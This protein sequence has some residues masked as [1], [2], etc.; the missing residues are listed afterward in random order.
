[1]TDPLFIPSPFFLLRAPFWS[2]EKWAQ[3]LNESNWVEAI[4]QLYDSDEAFQEAVAVASPNLD[5]EINKGEKK[6][7]EKIAYSLLKYAIRMSSRTTPFGLFSFISLGKWGEVTE[8]EINSLFVQ[9]G[10][11]PDLSWVYAYIEKLYKNKELFPALFVYKNPLIAEAQDRF[12]LEFH[13]QIEKDDHNQTQIKSIDKTIV[14]EA[15]FKLTDQEIEVS[16]L[17]D[18][19]EKKIDSSDRERLLEVILQLYEQQFLLP[20]LLPSLLSVS[21]FQDVLQKLPRDRF[22]KH[23]GNIIEQYQSTTIGEGILS[24]RNCMESM[25]EGVEVG[26]KLQVDSFYNKNRPILPKTIANAAI[27]TVNLYATLSRKNHHKEILKS[28]HEKFLEKYG[29]HRIVPILEVLSPEQ[30]L[31]DFKSE[32]LP[33]ISSQLEKN[34]EKWL[35]NQ[36]HDVEEEIVLTDEVVEDLLKKSGEKPFDPYEIIPSTDVFCQVLAES[37]EEIDRGN[38]RLLECYPGWQGGGTFGRFNYLFSQ[39][40]REEIEAFFREEEA[41]EPNALFVQTSIWP[42]TGNEANVSSL[43]CIRRHC[44]DLSSTEKKEADLTLE[45]VYVGANLEG[46]Y[47]TLR[48]GDPQL[49]C[50]PGHLLRP[51]LMSKPIELMRT[52]TLNNQNVIE[53]DFWGGLRKE[54][55]F[56][57]RIRYKKSILYPAMWQFD[58]TLFSHLPK[59]KIEQTFAIWSDTRKLPKKCLLISGDQQL[60]IETQHPAIRKEI[61]NRIMKKEVVQ[62]KEYLPSSWLKTDKGHHISELVIPLL[63][64]PKYRKEKDF[65]APSFQEVSSKQR[66]K[67]PGSEWISCKLYMSQREVDRFLINHL[68]DLGRQL[69]KEEKIYGWFFVRYH[70]PDFHLRF[71]LHLTQKQFFSEVIEILQHAVYEWIDNHFI[72]EFSLNTYE[73]ELERYGGSEMIELAEALFCVDAIG[74]CTQLKTVLLE[75]KEMPRSVYYALSVILFL[76]G[77]GLSNQE[78]INFIHIG[79]KEKERLAGFRSHKERLIADANSILVGKSENFHMQSLIEAAELRKPFQQLFTKDFVP[80]ATS[81]FSSLLHMHCNR[82]GCDRIE[83]EQACVWA[84]YTL[85]QIE[86]KKQAKISRTEM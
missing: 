24:L 25:K 84:K 4:F 67:I 2:I 7:T 53:P 81:L 50:C 82:L 52:I 8:V 61:I 5:R 83:E 15:I 44:L 19:L 22:L 51:Q 58:G 46:L 13:R 54:R 71:R 75:D 48:E 57:P 28:Y 45:D 21:P 26:T 20:S 33:S 63:K 36:S 73:R 37:K 14:T 40:E 35:Y 55:E 80:F 78:I 68:D 23:V 29:T 32:K 18:Q 47:L 72:K 70:D 77:F 39:K 64:H 9:K 10:V 62:F 31:G 11:R 43:P 49:F 76:S 38:F 16:V 41:L 3:I 34:L 1:M 74:C 86:S 66:L 6:R 60:L 69:M 42:L 85:K 12:F 65:R 17:C 59:Q 30:G 27:D 79:P 56:F